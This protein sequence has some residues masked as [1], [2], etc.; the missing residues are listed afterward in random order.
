MVAGSRA[1]SA[2]LLL[3]AY[4]SLA[5]NALK[6]SL[7]SCTLA[8]FTNYPHDMATVYRAYRCPEDFNKYCGFHGLPHAAGGGDRRPPSTA[9]NAW[10][11][12]DAVAQPG[13]RPGRPP[14]TRSCNLNAHCS[15]TVSGTARG[16]PTLVTQS[17]R[18][19]HAV[20]QN[21]G[22]AITPL[23]NGRGNRGR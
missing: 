18:T 11:P 2:P 22:F 23:P 15:G 13:Q 10:S 17:A 9:K 6:W 19:V 20:V 14:G 5:T 21:P 4:V 16:S 3:L 1:W 12:A 7:V 8:L